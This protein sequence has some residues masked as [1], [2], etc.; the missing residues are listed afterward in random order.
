MT[1]SWAVRTAEPGTDGDPAERLAFGQILEALAAAVDRRD[2][3][4]EGHSLRVADISAA[5]ALR[6]GWSR[7]D[8]AAL[9]GAGFVHDVGKIAVPADILASPRA[10][11]EAEFAQIKAHAAIGAQMTDGVLMPAQVAWIRHHHER[12]DGLGYPDGI[13]GQNIPAGARVM[14][15]ADSWDAMIS[16]RP[17]RDGL[18]ERAALEQIVQ[19]AASQYDSAVVEVFVEMF[20]SGDPLLSRARVPSRAHLQSASLG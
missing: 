19:G 11:T 9:K 4:T 16:D 18:S 14:A 3:L 15:V 10:L 1:E 6:M 20:E 7:S 12:W 5:I 2:P 17:F 13:D 8:A